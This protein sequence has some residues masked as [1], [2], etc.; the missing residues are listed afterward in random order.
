MQQVG[1]RLTKEHLCEG[2]TI[3]VP[4]RWRQEGRNRCIS[5]LWVVVTGLSFELHY[6]EKQEK[7]PSCSLTSHV[8]KTENHVRFF[9][10]LHVIL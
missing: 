7:I 3:S 5:T 8:Q 2:S 6:V 10:F 1:I 4:G 9:I